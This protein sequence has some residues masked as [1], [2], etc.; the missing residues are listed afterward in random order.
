MCKSNQQIKN[1][2]D[3]F[4]Y[5]LSFN[6]MNSGLTIITIY[7]ITNIYFNGVDPYLVAVL[8]GLPI[9]TLMAYYENIENDEP[10]DN[11]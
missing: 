7:T 1:I 6:I 9:I 8:V 4:N 2:K 3:I 5:H 11:L 10:K